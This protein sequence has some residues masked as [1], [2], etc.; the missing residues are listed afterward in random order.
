MAC[1]S[2]CLTLEISA[3]GAGLSVCS[4]ISKLAL[5]M[6]RHVTLWEGGFALWCVNNPSTVPSTGVYG[7]VVVMGNLA[8]AI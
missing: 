7:A 5:R 6:T 1:Y 8:I 3:S 4:S 2:N